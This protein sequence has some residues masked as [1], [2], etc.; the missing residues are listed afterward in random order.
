[1]TDVKQTITGDSASA[2]KAY[3]D[4]ARQVAKLE[5]ANQQMAAKAE[6]T[7]KRGSDSQK[8]L[9]GLLMKQVGILA[10]TAGAVLSLGNAWQIA[11]AAAVD[12]MNVSDRIRQSKIDIAKAETTLAINT[13]NRE[14]FQQY[15]A[16]A[17]DIA[18]KTSFSNLP[19]IIEAMAT[20]VNAAP[21][22]T[23]QEQR[24]NAYQAVYQGASLTK[25]K[26]ELLEMFVGGSL[27]VAASA[28]VSPHEATNLNLTAGKFARIANPERQQRAISQ[29]IASVTASS[30]VST[31][32]KRRK[33][34]ESGAEGWAA[35]NKASKDD[36]GEMS[37]TAWSQFG[38]YTGE[39]FTEG[40][41]FTPRGRSRPITI[42]PTEDPGDPV[43]RLEYLQKDRR[44]ANA[45]LD[46]YSFPQEGGYDARFKQAILDPENSEFVQNLK[47]AKSEVGYT[48]GTYEGGVAVID[49]GS[50][51]LE[52]AGQDEKSKTTTASAKLEGFDQ[53]ALAAQARKIR[54]DTLDLTAG[55]GVTGGFVAEKAIF[56]TTRNLEDMFASDATAAQRAMR[57]L[58]AK[59]LAVEGSVIQRGQESG[60]NPSATTDRQYRDYTSEE[61]EVIGHLAQAM[62]DLKPILERQEALAAQQLA[63]LK[64]P[65][66]N[67]PSAAGPARAEAGKGRER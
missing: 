53:R 7:T 31:P 52:L 57:E 34:A 28:G 45:F 21:G 1:M 37:R 47:G 6:Q 11:Q 26:P 3:A 18:D 15:R 22:A 8:M 24:Q 12:Y 55:W 38:S 17:L 43:G 63:E 23:P 65:P 19:I 16:D 54:N 59:K 51:S 50:K 14:E 9:S 2:Q 41:S 62:A 29:T 60:N 49:K 36:R 61:K 39:A 5:V 10:S 66:P 13:L 4:L 33:A 42:K 35:L 25:H 44:F 27:D 64:K 48:A 58:E 40:I 32:E 20:A 67:Q 56:G 46:K 30:D